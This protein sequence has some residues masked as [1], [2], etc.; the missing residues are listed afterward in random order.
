MS[1][2]KNL[3]K[4]NN[5]SEAKSMIT[6]EAKNAVSKADMARIN[7]IHTALRNAHQAIDKIYAA[8]ITADEKRQAMDQVYLEMIQIA[9]EGNN[10]IEKVNS[11]K[12]P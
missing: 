10:I 12:A 4:Q 2:A 5:L 8:P 9:N 1:T 6:S 11:A 7:E 3:V